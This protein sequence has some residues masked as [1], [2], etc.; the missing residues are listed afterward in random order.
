MA[1]YL[2]GNDVR[3]LN[4]GDRESRLK[5]LKEELMHERGIAAMGCSPPSPGKMRQLRRRIQRILTVNRE[6]ELGLVRKVKAGKTGRPRET[7][8]DKPKEA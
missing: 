6:D 8:S 3:Q 4:K 7:K 1:D 5:Q 2:R